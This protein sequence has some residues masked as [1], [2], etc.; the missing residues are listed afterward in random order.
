LLV[1]EVHCC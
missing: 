1:G